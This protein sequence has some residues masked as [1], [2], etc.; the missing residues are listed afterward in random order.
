M[1]SAHEGRRTMAGLTA[2]QKQA[3][4]RR[5]PGYEVVDESAVETDSARVRSAAPDAVSPDLE[6]ARESY[7]EG[8]ERPAKGNPAG[9]DEPRQGE[10]TIA[11]IRPK[12]TGT[13]RAGAGPKQVI[14][15]SDGN[16]IAE[17]G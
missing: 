7:F 16:P 9:D 15:D 4:E 10:D 3:L 12:V 13:D 1:G 2:K 6:K 17:Q 14:I 8:G 11:I 5:Y